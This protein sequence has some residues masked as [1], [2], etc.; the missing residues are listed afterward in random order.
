MAPTIGHSSSP[1]PSGSY[2]H[3]NTATPCG[4]RRGFAGS[5]APAMTTIRSVFVVDWTHVEGIAWGRMAAMLTD[6]I[7]ETL[8]VSSQHPMPDTMRVDRKSKWSSPIW[9]T[10]RKSVGIELDHRRQSERG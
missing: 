9:P 2:G 3:Q 1:A 10:K 6:H 5:A 8:A 7:E 4:E